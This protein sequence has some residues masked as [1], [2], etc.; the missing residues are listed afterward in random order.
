MSFTTQT[1]EPVRSNRILRGVRYGEFFA[2]KR[3]GFDLEGEVWNTFGVGDCPPEQWNALD[4]DAMKKRM[5]VDAVILNGP[6]FWTMD[7]VEMTGLGQEVLEFGA[8][9]VR[10]IATVRFPISRIMQGRPPYKETTI[11]RTTSFG[12]MAGKPVYE[13][14]APDK[15]Y[16]MQSYS[17][18]LDP[19]LTEADLPRLGQR[20]H[21]PSGWQY[22]ARV[23]DED[24]ELRVHGKAT[25]LQDDLQNTYHAA[26][27]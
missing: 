10:K 1:S 22:R 15:T 5:S 8:I 13:L 17:H 7:S 4:T 9:K 2:V 26:T 25:I 18:T 24:L 19:S 27:E 21:V 12:F 3:R 11:G 20:L 6:R 16:V 23:L 14:V